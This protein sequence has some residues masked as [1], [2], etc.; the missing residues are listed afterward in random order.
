MGMRAPLAALGLLVAAA[1]APRSAAADT[2]HTV[3]AG[4]NLAT[5]AK[6]YGVSQASLAAANGI[7]SGSTV[8]PG[9]RLSV[10]EPGVVVVNPG[11]T[12]WSVARRN[13]C[14][15]EA[16]ARANGLSE[17]ASLRP[18]MHL[19]LPGQHPAS[20]AARAAN[21]KGDKSWG[22]P[23]QRGRAQLF[24]IATDES[25]TITLVDKRGRVRPQA[26]AQLARFLRPRSAPQKIKPPQ[27][28]LIGLLAQVSDHFGGR[29]ISVV[30]GYRLAGGYTSHASRH[31]AG[32]AI[33]LR[34]DGVTNKQL[35]DYLRHFEDVGVGFY[36]NS[37]FVHFDIR[38]RNAF[39]VDVSGPGQ[40]PQYLSREDR[41]NYPRYARLDQLKQVG[42]VVNAALDDMEHGEPEDSA[43]D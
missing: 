41:D 28:R 12:L 17:G 14:T 26:P 24:R 6:K 25:L 42:A 3:A 5:I 23:K 7:D 19:R 11:Q 31:V 30:S 8:R 32:A 9:Q 13:G 29:K 43:D 27:K 36:P 35:A 1:A 15:V 34:V 21:K 2:Q 40:K 33:D 20:S 4:Q 37:T 18:G 16:L 39:W 22:A 38:D 10:P